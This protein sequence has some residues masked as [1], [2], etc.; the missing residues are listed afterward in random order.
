MFILHSLNMI[1]YFSKY[2][3]F[4]DLEALRFNRQCIEELKNDI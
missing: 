4:V 3:F 2:G 1:Y